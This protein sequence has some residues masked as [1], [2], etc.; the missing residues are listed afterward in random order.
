MT[1]TADELQRRMEAPEYLAPTSLTAYANVS[2]EFGRY[3]NVWSPSPQDV[4]HDEDWEKAV[5]Q[6]C[7]SARLTLD[8]LFQGNYQGGHSFSSGV[9]QR[10]T[11]DTLESASWSDFIILVPHG[12]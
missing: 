7:K 2:N 10:S 1:V 6:S 11:E 5:R 12:G 9:T 3:F 4:A 8:S